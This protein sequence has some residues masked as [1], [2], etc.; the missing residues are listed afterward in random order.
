MTCRGRA[1]TLRLDANNTKE[2][3]MLNSTPDSHSAHMSSTTPT[4]RSLELS[5]HNNVG[6]SKYQAERRERLKRY[7]ASVHQTVLFWKTVHETTPMIGEVSPGRL[8]RHRPPDGGLS[9]DG[10]HRKHRSALRDRCFLPSRRPLA[11][12]ESTITGQTS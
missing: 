7:A 2:M 11:L 1:D 4:A 9:P 8:R 12:Q 3:S 6:R 10:R 5:R